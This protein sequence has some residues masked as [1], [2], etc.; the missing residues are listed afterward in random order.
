MTRNL[1]ILFI[2]RESFKF[3][4]VHAEGKP[5]LSGPE[6]GRGHYLPQV[7]TDAV[8]PH[9]QRH[10]NLKKINRNIN[11]QQ[12]TAGYHVHHVH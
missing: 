2:I 9:P 8:L 5:E 12:C 7:W 4:T 6:E 1:I 10:L 3:F 11:L